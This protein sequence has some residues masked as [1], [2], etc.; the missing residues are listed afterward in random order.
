[1]PVSTLRKAPAQCTHPC[2]M[3]RAHACPQ[4]R[5]STSGASTH[6]SAE[7][8][9][10]LTAAAMLYSRWDA[11]V[12]SRPFGWNESGVLQDLLPRLSVSDPAPLADPYP[13]RVC[14]MHYFMAVKLPAT[15]PNHPRW[16]ICRVQVIASIHVQACLM[17]LRLYIAQAIAAILGHGAINLQGPG[18]APVQVFGQIALSSIGW[19]ASTMTSSLAPKF[20]RVVAAVLKY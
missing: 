1:M 4:I 19:N 9:R 20:E 14:P 18:S 6:T 12:R 15:G 2:W 16:S 7:E 8:G 5:G 10:V 11:L 17:H 3:L 13:I